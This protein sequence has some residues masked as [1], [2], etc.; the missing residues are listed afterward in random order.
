LT[1]LN[2]GCASARNYGRMK[3]DASHIA[4]VDADDIPGPGLFT[5]LLDL[6]RHTGAEITQGGFELLTTGPDGSLNHIPSYEV[7]IPEVI[8]AKRHNFGDQT[9]FMMPSWLLL[10]GQPTI[11]RRI[12][13]RDF[14]DNRNIWFPEHIRAFDDQIFQV[15]TLQNIQNVPTLDGVNYFY[16]QHPGQ[17]IKQGDERAFYSLEMFRMVLK[18][19]VSEGWNEF[20]S[21]LQSYMNTVNWCWQGLRPD[22]RPAFVRGAAELWVYARNTLDPKCFDGLSEDGFVPP[23]FAYFTGNFHD[24][25]SSLDQSYGNVYLDSADMHVSMVVRSA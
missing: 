20:R 21:V 23:D 13:R 2:G 7:T 22:L 15:L 9:C 1:K 18:R 10:Q 16:R 11:W 4:F 12:Y 19:G 17:D 6:A 3:S 8:H 25:L 14:L 24:K 5:G